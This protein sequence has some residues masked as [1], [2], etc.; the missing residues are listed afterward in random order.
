MKKFRIIYVI[1]LLGFLSACVGGVGEVNTDGYIYSG[2]WTTPKPMGNDK[3]FTEGYHTTD[4]INGA[5]EFCKRKGKMFDSIDLKP[6]NNRDNTRAS[7]I[8]KCV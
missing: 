4:A 5:I 2:Q 6:S 1:C 7:L 3:F 8:F